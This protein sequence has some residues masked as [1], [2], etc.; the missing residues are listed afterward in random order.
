LERLKK[1]NAPERVPLG[2]EQRSGVVKSQTPVRKTL[3]RRKTFSLIHKRHRRRG[4]CRALG[5]CSAESHADH[6]R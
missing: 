2:R 1:S 6:E 4:G 5:V 3:R